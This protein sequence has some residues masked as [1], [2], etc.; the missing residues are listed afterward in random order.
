MRI[1]WFGH[2]LSWDEALNLLTSQA[3]Y[4]RV[5]N[6]FSE[7]RLRYPPFHDGL[8]FL[9]S[10]DAEGFALR[11][12]ALSLGFSA[13]ALIFTWLLNRLALG[14]EEALWSAAALALMPAAVFFDRWIKQ[15]VPLAAIG[16]FALVCVAVRRYW[17]AGILMGLAFTVKHMAGFYVAAIGVM[18]LPIIRRKEF[19]RAVLVL[20]LGTFLVGGWWYLGRLGDFA[21]FMSFAVG[22]MNSEDWIKPMSYYAQQAPVDLGWVGLVLGV[23]GFG[24]LLRRARDFW[25]N[26]DPVGL[27]RVVWP[28]ALLVPSLTAIHLSH[29]K[30]P[31]YTIVLYPAAAT[32]VGLGACNVGLLFTRRSLRGEKVGL[33]VGGALLLLN[34]GVSLWGVSYEKF[35][36]A[37]DE[38]LMLANRSSKLAGEMVARQL[39][40]GEDYAATGMLYWNLQDSQWCGV[41]VFYAGRTPLVLLPFG[42][43]GADLVRTCESAGVELAFVSVARGS[44]RDSLLEDIFLA[45]PA[46]QIFDTAAGVVVRLRKVASSTADFLP[47]GVIEKK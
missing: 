45:C 36:G 16:S 12:E 35:F 10:P 3:D 42:I 7:W 26:G 37:K 5:E 9:L 6:P 1:P 11:A 24:V 40:V 46:A 27:G 22:G 34:Y 19:W 21:W 18:L 25:H 23:L 41:F 31:W 4:L 2:L 14:R 28:L 32:L 20:A 8:L 43:S 47:G 38:R 15:D 33:L 39:R 17:A 13:L 30:T 44:D 29:G